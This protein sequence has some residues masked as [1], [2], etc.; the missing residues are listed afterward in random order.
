M[1]GRLDGW[2]FEDGR[3]LEVVF[4]RSGLLCW[5]YGGEDVGKG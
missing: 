5:F 4:R 3:V 2:T 1:S